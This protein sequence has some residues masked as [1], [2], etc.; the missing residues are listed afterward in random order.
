MLQSDSVRGSR[1]EDRVQHGNSA[2]RLLPFDSRPSH[3]RGPEWPKVRERSLPREHLRGLG[4]RVPS[5]P[6]C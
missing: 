5:K 3:C 2:N 4:Y 6:R 1:V